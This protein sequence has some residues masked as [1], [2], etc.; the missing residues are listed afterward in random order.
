MIRLE[1][2]A[3]SFPRPDPTGRIPD[4]G[5]P[6]TPF[7][8]VPVLLQAGGI[9]L[10]SADADADGAKV[11]DGLGLPLPEVALWGLVA[12]HHVR[13]AG[14]SVYELNEHGTALLFQ[15][16]KDLLLLHS[17]RRERTVQVPYQRMLMVWEEFDLRVRLF[18]IQTFGHLIDYPRWNLSLDQWLRGELDVSAMRPPSASLR[19]LDD[20]EQCFDKI[21]AVER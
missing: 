4:V 9:D 3:N 1:F 11:C 6:R 14:R 18:L 7:R 17:M 16:N 2:D 5:R 19:F 15:L 10:I 20:C 13:R 21:D 12:L 8:F